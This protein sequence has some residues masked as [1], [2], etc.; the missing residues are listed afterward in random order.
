[1][2]PLW[3]VW[4]RE[5]YDWGCLSLLPPLLWPWGITE[6]LCELRGPRGE[7]TICGAPE[8]AESLPLMFLLYVCSSALSVGPA[9]EIHVKWGNQDPSFA[10][11]RP[12]LWNQSIL[13]NSRIEMCIGEWWVVAMGLAHNVQKTLRVEQKTGVCPGQG[14]PLGTDLGDSQRKLLAEVVSWHSRQIIEG[15]LQTP[16]ENSSK[17]RGVAPTPSPCLPVSLIIFITWCLG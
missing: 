13:E 4:W 15:I 7:P 16:S 12:K 9:A 3:P 2:Q 5:M 11:R 8:L 17:D 14:Q 6:K 10:L 1:M